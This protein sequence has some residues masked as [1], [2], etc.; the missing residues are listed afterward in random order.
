VLTQVNGGTLE[1]ISGNYIFANFIILGWD[2]GYTGSEDH[3]DL[4]FG[5]LYNYNG[6]TN[7]GRS[8]RRIGNR[9]D[10]YAKAQG[11]N[12]KIVL[13]YSVVTLIAS[14]DHEFSISWT[15]SKDTT[16]FDKIA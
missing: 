10:L 4:I 16:G 1:M 6:A 11:T 8:F 3:V 13:D 2:Y 12:L 14:A 7:I 9:K 15:D 5:G